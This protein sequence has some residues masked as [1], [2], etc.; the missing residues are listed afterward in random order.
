MVTPGLGPA[1]LESRDAAFSPRSAA[2]AAKV[3]TRPGI[4]VIGASTGG[5]QALITLI[6]KLG[7]ALPFVPVCVTLHMPR[8]LMPVVAAHVQRRCGVKTKVIEA[9]C[10][11]DRG[12][13]HFAPGDKHLDFRRT[14]DGVEM[15]LLPAPSRNYCKPAIDTMFTAA[16]RVFGPRAV[17]IVLSGMGE[18][19]LAGA[20][21]IAAAGGILLVQD[22]ATSAVWGM[23]GS[24][25]KAG[26][27][28]AVLPPNAIADEVMR[29]LRSS[30]AIR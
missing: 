12:V 8:D 11:I 21:A 20:R 29:R 5:P 7:S 2:S 13:V 26:L 4:V 10:P 3:V 9:P 19:G 1:L 15:S 28:A 23:P 24:V 30:G 17:G 27:A 14:A 16:A 18:D 22:K 6:S 25:A